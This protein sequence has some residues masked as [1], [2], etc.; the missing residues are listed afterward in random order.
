MSQNSDKDTKGIS[1]LALA[2]MLFAALSVV[3][4]LLGFGVTLAVEVVFG[5]PHAAVFES[6]AELLDLSSTALME[7][8][9]TIVKFI[10]EP[11]SYIRLYEENLLSLMAISGSTVLVIFF[12]GLMKF[13]KPWRSIKF[14]EI[15]KPQFLGVLAIHSND[16]K[17]SFGKFLVASFAAI[18]LP[19]FTPL[20]AVALVAIVLYLSIF[21]AMV[22]LIG[23]NSGVSYIEKWVLEPQSCHSTQS[24]ADILKGLRERRNHKASLPDTS[25][26][27]SKAATCVAV[28]KDKEE[29]AR[30]RVVLHTSKA[31]L[32]LAKDG[33]VRRVPTTD[34]VI[35][36]VSDITVLPEKTSN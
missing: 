13:G 31:V 17:T 14:P 2:G 29:I 26:P 1:W 21:F 25:N 27:S 30:G 22:P 35:E 10:L 3:A 34:A 20:L 9:P 12:I 6:T 32:L 8:I 36:I 4:L 5:M 33:Q 19:F 24:P 23:M 7:I 28:R 11:Q 15:R 18:I 16:G